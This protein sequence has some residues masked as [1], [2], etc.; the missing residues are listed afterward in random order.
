MAKARESGEE[1]PPPPEPELE[2][3][4]GM[5]G[6]ATVLPDVS[7]LQEAAAKVV[8]ELVEQLNNL[9]PF[10]VQVIE[11]MPEA[12]SLVIMFIK[13]TDCLVESKSA[14]ASRG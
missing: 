1:A 4:P 13:N 12:T 6:V 2:R 11:A 14:K 9:P 5:I 7:V 10:G 8:T 3:D